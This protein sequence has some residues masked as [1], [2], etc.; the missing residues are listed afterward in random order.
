MIDKQKS[1][2]NKICKDCL[3]EL[4]EDNTNSY[5]IEASQYVCKMCRKSRDKQ[6]YINRKEIIREQQRLYDLSIKMKVITAYGG[7]CVCCAENALEFLTIDAPPK[8]KKSGG[9]L[10]RWLI[11][12]NFPQDNYQLLCCNCSN[13]KKL[14]GYC[15]H[16]NII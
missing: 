12:N 2:K 4:T 1:L 14:F 16:K 10:Y 3:V 7:K 6:K 15:P 8:D 11:N 5:D 9:K 13:S